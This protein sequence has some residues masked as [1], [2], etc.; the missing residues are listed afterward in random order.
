MATTNMQLTLPAVS[1]TPGP[2]WATLLNAAL[3]KIDEHDHSSTKGVKVPTAG[4]NIN[5]DL[6]CNEYGLV[7]VRKVDLYQNASDP[8]GS[9]VVYNKNGDLYFRNGSGVNVKIT[10]GSGL[11]VAS[12][13]GIGGDYGSGDEILDY[14]TS[15]TVY[16][17]KKDNTSN[18]RAYIDSAAITLRDFADNTKNTQILPS[19]SNSY[20]LRLFPAV[21]GSTLKRDVTIENTGGEA[22]FGFRDKDDPKVSSGTI[23][24]LSSWTSTSTTDDFLDDGTSDVEV[25]FK[26][27]AGRPVV[28]KLYVPTSTT[29]FVELDGGI[30]YSYL[31][32]DITLYRDGVAVKSFNATARWSGQGVYSINPDTVSFIDIPVSNGTYTYKMA[33]KSYTAGVVMKVRNCKILAY[34]L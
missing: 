4:I 16:T 10:S 24:S 9:G 14:T 3:T 19:G 17:F 11:N 7:S 31:S 27:E 32:A 34:Q 33:M 26:A 30:S 25:S 29:G 28:V 6:N 2:T 15:G 18:N 13:G 12:L 20:L 1:S 8:T 21:P 23:G 22:I 5:A